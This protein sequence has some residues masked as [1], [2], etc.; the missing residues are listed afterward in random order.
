MALEILPR[1]LNR[2]GV[3]HGGVLATL[4]DTVGGFAGTYCTVPGTSAVRET[5]RSPRRR[6]PRPAAAPCVLSAGG[7]A[8]DEELHGACE[9]FDERDKLIAM[10]EGTY[11][12]RSGSEDPE[13]DLSASV[14]VSAGSSPSRRRRRGGRQRG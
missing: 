13:G 6:C 9:I 7:V 3:V 14:P 4:L 11:R 2:A 8:E 10:G 12:Y 1:H 5:L